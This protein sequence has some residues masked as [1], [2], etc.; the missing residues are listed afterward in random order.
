MNIFE[1][2]IPLEFNIFEEKLR[3]SRHI[4]FVL[5]LSRSLLPVVS[6]AISEIITSIFSP[7]YEKIKSCDS[8]CKKSFLINLTLLIGFISFISTDTIFPFKIFLLAT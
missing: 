3:T 6:A 2:R 1:T 4:E 5:I 7:K 8:S